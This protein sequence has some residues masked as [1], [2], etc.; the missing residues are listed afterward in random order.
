M[1]TFRYQ[2]DP[3]NRS[4]HHGPTLLTH[5]SAAAVAYIDDPLSFPWELLDPDSLS[6]V[7]VI[8]VSG[9][10]Q[11]D[12]IALRPALP[13]L[14][15]HDTIC[16][17]SDPQRPATRRFAELVGANTTEPTEASTSLLRRHKQVEQA[18]AS[19]LKRAHNEW[20]TLTVDIADLASVDW[21]TATWHDPS[22]Q[23]AVAVAVQ[24]P[25]S[26]ICEN[27]D[28]FAQLLTTVLTTTA[29]NSI[30]GVWGVRSD[31]GEPLDRAVVVLAKATS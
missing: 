12:L 22:D 30:L 15:A 23:R 10:S 26:V 8:D 9:C 2:R 29:T 16:S 14:T 19:I 28:G 5:L 13:P 6:C 25:A 1:T 31:A 27:R 11:D 20:Q 21:P 24:I 7:F 4:E 18:E 17:R 3:A